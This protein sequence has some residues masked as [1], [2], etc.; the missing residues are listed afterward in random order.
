MP[1]ARRSSQTGV[2]P[3]GQQEVAAAQR[4][5]SQPRALPPRSGSPQPLIRGARLPSRRGPG[6]ALS[7]LRQKRQLAS[8]RRRQEQQQ[9][10]QQQLAVA[11]QGVR[12]SRDAATSTEGEA[13][14]GGRQRNAAVQADAQ[15]AASVPRKET[16]PAGSTAAAPPAAVPEGYAVCPVHRVL[17][18]LPAAAQGTATAPPTPHPYTPAAPPVAPAALYLQPATAPGTPSYHAPPAGAWVASPAHAAVQHGYAAI[19]HALAASAPQSPQRQIQ[20]QLLALP[21]AQPQAQ[22]QQQQQPGSCCAPFCTAG[23]CQQHSAG[24]TP[25]GA[26]YRQCT[27]AAQQQQMVLQPVLPVQLSAGSYQ[28]MPGSPG[29]VYAAAVQL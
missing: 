1:A 23:P 2:Q 29:G 17:V 26:G 12:G 3:G 8:P 18:P 25:T 13:A 14:A 15:P 7:P 27:A 20:L 9:A 24:Y 16:P 6:I 28:P 21:V 22:A 5:A 11:R 10:Q 19:R 4:G